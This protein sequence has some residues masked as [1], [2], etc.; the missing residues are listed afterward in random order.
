[1][2]PVSK[3]HKLANSNLNI[4]EL[5][6]IHVGHN[7][8]GTAKILST[9]ERIFSNVEVISKLDI[10]V[11]AGDFF[12]RDLSLPDEEVYEIRH[13]I[14]NLIR[15]CKD[16]DIVLRVL[17]GTPSH[18]WKQSKLFTHLNE[19]TGI[20]ADVKFVDKLSIEHI[21]RFNLDVLYIPDEWR[22]TTEETQKDVI[23]KLKQHGL[24]QVDLVIM[25]GCFAH[26]MP[27]N[28]RDKLD[29][30]DADFFQS[31]T[32]YFIFVGHIHF[33]SQ[34]GKILSAGSVER[35]AHGEEGPKGYLVVSVDRL[36]LQ[37]T[38]SFIE[39]KEATVYKTINCSGLTVAQSL[40]K[41]RND[42]P[43]RN[44]RMFIRILCKSGDDVRASLS[45]LALE[46]P[47]VRWKTKTAEEAKVKNFITED[48]VN[49]P[50]GIT[51]TADNITQL[52]IDRVLIKNPVIATRCKELL[53]EVLDG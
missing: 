43:K 7:N 39:N 33:F 38:I 25:H 13:F 37:H 20:N 31:I 53:E 49:I 10:I 34:Y 17:E 3:E 4:L 50:T 8:T 28:I 22:A 21:E 15:T 41:I 26:Q 24:E 51:I 23:L 48:K 11:I 36:N 44:E 12:D 27:V 45:E 18:D 46:F 2:N 14:V 9:L 30:H 42:I 19:V 40:E 16:Y 47:T 52:L 5:S 29:T 32:R 6:D 1:M 35:L